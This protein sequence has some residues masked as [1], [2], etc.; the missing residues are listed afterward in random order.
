MERGR[1]FQT[2]L[3][4][5]EKDYLSSHQCFHQMIVQKLA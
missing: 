3:L 1:Y 4:A 5:L 2:R